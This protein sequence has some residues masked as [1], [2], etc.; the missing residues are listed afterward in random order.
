M[1]NTQ[2]PSYLLAVTSAMAVVA[3]L[4]DYKSLTVDYLEQVLASNVLPYEYQLLAQANRD[5]VIEAYMTG[6]AS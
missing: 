2:A 3:D 5:Y 6:I 1:N 4:D